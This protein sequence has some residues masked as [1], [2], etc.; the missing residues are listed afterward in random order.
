[1]AAASVSLSVHN[2]SISGNGSSASAPYRRSK[3]RL[4]SSSFLITFPCVRSYC[5][6][7]DS[8]CSAISSCDPDGSCSIFSMLRIRRSVIK[9][10]L[11]SLRISLMRYIVKSPARVE[12]NKTHHAVS[13]RWRFVKGGLMPLII[14]WLPLAIFICLLLRLS[15]IKM[16]SVQ[17]KFC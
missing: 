10:L 3:T 13:S 6:T 15:Q 2:H 8:R 11:L 17:A 1:M 7:S 4:A 14:T 12:H 16:V 9:V 5:S